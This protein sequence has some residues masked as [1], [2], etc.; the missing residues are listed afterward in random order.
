MAVV[1]YRCPSTGEYV[2]TAIETADHVLVRMRAMDLTLWVWCPHCV[3]GHQIK[4]AEA[5]LET[6]ASAAGG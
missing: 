3:A 6:E 4:P 2:M 1:G 5:T